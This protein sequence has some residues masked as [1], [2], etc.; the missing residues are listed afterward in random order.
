MKAMLVMRDALVSW[1]GG[2]SLP[3]TRVYLIIRDP[4]DARRIAEHIGASVIEFD[5][6]CERRT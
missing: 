4:L 2:V 5:E 1:L 6:R 3:E